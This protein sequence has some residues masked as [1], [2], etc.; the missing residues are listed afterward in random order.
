[1]G[2]SCE[3]RSNILLSSKRLGTCFCC[4]HKEEVS[5]WPANIGCFHPF[6]K[7]LSI[8]F[9]SASVRQ[10]LNQILLFIFFL[11]DKRI[12]VSKAGLVFIQLN[13]PINVFSNI[14]T[15][16]A[17]VGRVIRHLLLSL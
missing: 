6:L 11:L 1:M 2:S 9:L 8:F 14:L 10:F 3:I 13:Q 16:S 7:F 15:C 12:Y 4:N 5:P 17:S